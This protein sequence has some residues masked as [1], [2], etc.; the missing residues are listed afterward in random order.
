MSY[1]KGKHPDAAH[2]K[3]IATVLRAVADDLDA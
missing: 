2:A 1:Q 3:K